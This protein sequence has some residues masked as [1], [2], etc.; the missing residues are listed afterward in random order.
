MTKISI[1]TFSP[2]VNKKNQRISQALK[3]LKANI[4]PWNRLENSDGCLIY[5]IHGS[6]SGPIIQASKANKPIISLQ[7]GMF[8]IGWKSTLSAMRK[9]CER[10]NK[11]NITQFVWSKFERENYIKM[12]RKPELVK[13]FG[14]PEHDLLTLPPKI[15]KSNYNL[16]EDAFVI[17]HIDQ[18]AHPRGGPNKKDIDLMCSQIERLT[19]LDKRIWC[20]RSLHPIRSKGMDKKS[21]GRVIVRPFTYP[22]FDFVRMADLVITLSSTEGLTS[23]ILN[24]H[25]IQYDISNSKE[26]WP[27]VEHGVAVRA[28]SYSKLIELT[29]LALDDKLKIEPNFDYKMIYQVDGNATKR[30][31]ENIIKK[32]ESR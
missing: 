18:Y 2:V 9:E 32:I 31:A 13:C 11:Y 1:H 29:Q 4:I 15:T 12:G 19:S 5:N 3:K 14:N 22:I 16:P 23:A 7:E 17:L 21:S 10:A 28:T 30:V 6:V 27:F 26:R 8:A 20:I 25:I 24:K